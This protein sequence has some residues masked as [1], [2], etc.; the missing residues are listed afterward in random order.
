MSDEQPLPSS[1]AN[2][3]VLP[4]RTRFLRTFLILS[5]LAVPLLIVW[6]VAAHKEVIDS[7][8]LSGG[9]FNVRFLAAD[10]GTLNYSSDTR[11]QAVLRQWLPRPLVQKL[12][13]ELRIG[14]YRAWS[15]HPGT[16]PLVLLFQL[17]TSVNTVQNETTDVFD[18]I[19]FPESTGYVFVHTIGGYT[20]HGLGTSIQQFEAFPRRDRTLTFRLYQDGGKLLM[21]K[22]VN[23]PAYQASFSEWTPEPLPALKQVEDVIVHLTE[24]KVADNGMTWPQ[25]RV[26]STDASWLNPRTWHYWTDATGN[27][28]D[29]LSPFEPAWKLHVS[30]SRRR[31][32][33]FPESS[34]WTSDPIPLPV[35]LSLSTVDREKYVDGVRLHFRY[36]APASEVHEEAGKVTVKESGQPGRSGF[37]VSAGSRGSGAGMV[38]YSSIDCGVP[39]IRLDHDALPTGVELLIDVLDDQGRLLNDNM[40]PGQNGLNNIS[41]HGVTFEPKRDTKTVR[42]RARVSRS[43]GVEFVVAPPKVMRERSSA[44]LN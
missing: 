22:S 43:K 29:Q 44:V 5:L 32:A 37:S 24:L 39:Y 26:E 21:E 3:S 1:R 34:E 17:L 2:H 9:K 41:F 30:L 18:R 35:G 6:R 40:H 25:F 11:L 15:R 19:E 23:N 31:D 42:L 28:G 4:A 10:V 38:S 14:G 16:K 27:A 12:G 7:V 33:Q 8:P 20:S 36:V 13:P